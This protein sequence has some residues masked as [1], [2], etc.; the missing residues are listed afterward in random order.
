[1]YKRGLTGPA[2]CKETVRLFKMVAEKGPW[3]EQLSTAHKMYAEGNE[4]AAL[5]LFAQL[6]AVGVESAQYNAAYIL[7]KCTRCPPVDKSS[8]LLGGTSMSATTENP[9]VSDPLERQHRSNK[10]SAATDFRK[11]LKDHEAQEKLARSAAKS[12]GAVD[13]L[14]AET[15]AVSSV[16]YLPTDAWRDFL[17][18]YHPDSLVDAIDLEF[19]TGSYFICK[20][21]F[22]DHVCRVHQYLFVFIQANIVYCIS[23]VYSYHSEQ[24]GRQRR[25]RSR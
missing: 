10:H 13:T 6:A 17:R 25:Q 3:M 15:S 7:S 24:S 22:S 20:N 8:S 23:Y 12:S 19:Q 14:A 18:M 4:L 21:Y 1:M 5:H 2:S 11:L 9:F 16:A